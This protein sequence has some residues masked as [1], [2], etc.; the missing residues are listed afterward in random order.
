MRLPNV[1]RAALLVSV[2]LLCLPAFAQ[3]I[4][5]SVK[6]IVVD[7]TGAPVPAAACT[8]TH[9]A[10]GT[11]LKTNSDAEGSFTFPSVL[12]GMY[13]LRVEVAG[14]KTTEMRNI[15]VVASEIHTLGT[16]RLELGEVSEQIAVTGQ[17]APVQLASGE[18]ASLLTS[19]QFDQ[20]AVKGRDFF[21]LL[22]T[23]PGVVDDFS[24]SRN[25]TSGTGISGIYINGSRPTQKNYTV[26]GVT[27][28][29]TGSNNSTHYEPNMDAIA[30]VR[31]LTSN[32]QA[33]LGR[34][35]GGVITVI[36]KSGTQQFHG[37]AYDF[38]RHEAL[39]ANSFFN[40]RTNTPKS[41]YRYRISGYS[42]GGPVYIPNKFNR[43]RSK[44]FFF[45]SQEFTGQKQAFTPQL[46]NMPT[47]AERTGDFSQSFDVNGKLIAVRD[48]QSGAPFPGNL[49]PASRISKLGQSMLNFFPSPNYVDS[50][51]SNLYRWNYRSTYSG[52]YPRREELVRVDWNARPDLQIYYRYI[53]DKDEQTT[54][55]SMYVNGSVNYN[56]DPVIYGQPGS[57]H[58]LHVTKTFSPSL[59]NEFTFGRDRN[60]LYCN[61]VDAS[62]VDRSKMGNPSQWYADAPGNPTNYFPGANP[63]PNVSFGGQPI[64]PVNASLSN[65]PPNLWFNNIYNI[66]D[67]V[68]KVW[69]G[70]TFKAGL[71]IE[72]SRQTGWSDSNYKGAFSFSVDTNNPLN[73]NNAFASALLGYITSYSET[74]SHVFADVRFRNVEWYVQDNWKVTRRL[75]L[76][77]GLRFSHQPPA[78][79][80]NHTIA[81]FDPTGYSRSAAPTLYQPAINTSGQRVAQNP[82]TGAYAATP[83]I[84]QFVPG[85]GNFA[86][87]MRVAGQDGYPNGLITLP[88]L[89]LGPRFGFAYDVFGTG[90]TALRGGFGLFN[91]RL[92]NNPTYNA[93]G[94]PPVA[95]T[96]TLYYG[97][98]DTYAQSSGAVGPSTVRALY[99]DAKPSITMNYSLGLQHR[100]WSTVAEVSYV[101]AISRHLPLG[102]DI[103]VIPMYAHFD[104][105]HADPTQPSLP[106]P[107][108]FLR[109]YQGYGSL[110]MYTFSGTSNYNS[111]QASVNRRFTSGLQF[112][113]AYTFSKALG[114]ASGESSTVSP[115][116]PARQRNYGPLTFD[117]SQFFVVNYVYDLPK[118]GQRLG[119]KPA[120]WVLDNWQI[121]GVTSLISGAPFTPGFST[122]DGADITGSSES[123][124]VNVVGNPA[125]SKGD[126]TF[127]RNFDTSVFRR[128]A[129][130][131]FGNIGVNTLRGP[132]VNNWDI[133]ISKRFPL[134]SEQ[135]LLQFRTEMFNTWNHTQFSALNSTARFDAAG[136]QIDSTFGSFT[137]ARTPRIIELSLKFYF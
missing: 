84:G 16:I 122:T 112:G 21:A 86:N 26:D 124:R 41:P 20:I 5:S 72:T 46:V 91:D 111:L 65:R 43:D 62:L 23:M 13:R 1:T 104:A 135:R 47:A 101:G 71:Y 130:G 68:S 80:A 120:G 119:S 33:E 55:W 95:Y 31:V 125:I 131:D 17:G 75:T 8:L 92:D 83:L 37:S 74:T 6:G 73:T 51:A 3:N 10:T 19:A 108:N 67:N 96:P 9:Q 7:P 12:A 56:M 18:K 44:L 85:S 123:A 129:K 98:L 58:V 34:N 54:P 90:K 61:Y 32:Y 107:D 82:L 50:N 110:T 66:V 133:A 63:I 4:S 113:V 102:R 45:W 106:L 36:T 22:L 115:Y 40:N 128:P 105:K 94:N 89:A 30:E 14:F 15:A 42:I 29:D 134:R 109:P 52:P 81:G 24:Q 28:M 127:D 126:K 38:Y 132:G 103:N 93:I 69:R 35:S 70:H 117:R 27:A 53:Q 121:S 118:V 79:D 99:G 116:F 11:M 49:I 57:G 87:G 39:N 64:N 78:Y 77:F 136:N 48:P 59:V 137:A 76:D 2:C 88:W 60:H 97:T 114:V 100:V 25:A